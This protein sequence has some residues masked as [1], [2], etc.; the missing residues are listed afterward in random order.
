[1]KLET[2]RVA[3]I[4]TGV[5]A[6]TPAMT[7]PLSPRPPVSATLQLEFAAR[8]DD[9]S[10]QTILVGSHQ[11]PPLKVVRA[12][13]LEDGSALAHLHNVSGGVLGGDRLFL[14][15]SVGA[16]ASVQLTT[17]G[18]TRIYRPRAGEQESV[19]T[20]EIDVEDGGLLEY[21]PDAVIPFAG[22]RFSQRTRVRLAPGAGLFW[23][24]IVAP[25]REARGEVFAYD[26]VELRTDLHAG[27]ALIAAER[28]RLE[29]RRAPARAIGRLGDFR[30][31]AT[32]YI[33]RVGTATSDWISLEQ[34][35]RSLFG[36][37]QHRDSALWSVSTL[38]EHGLAVRCA[39]KNG[40]AIV[41]G[42]HEIWRTAKWRLYERAAIAPR[43][44]N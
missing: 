5:G 14:R 16:A 11:E 10:A 29:P 31:W 13:S 42:L 38:P 12:F 19:Q 9:E 18:A 7:E 24:E 23:W 30:T 41:A 35:L 17:T 8:H 37:L 34:E 3:L 6:V 26:R 44:V 43:K 36:L 21:L 27:G 22:A 2:D 20:T 15:V 25:G 33:C 4:A 28:V 39:A 40:R 1:M 32:F